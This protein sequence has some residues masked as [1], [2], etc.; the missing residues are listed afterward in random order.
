MSWSGVKE[1]GNTQ[2]K[3]KYHW[4][5]MALTRLLVL[6]WDTQRQN[7]PGEGRRSIHGAIRYLVSIF[8]YERAEQLCWHRAQLA[9]SSNCTGGR[10]Y[11]A[12]EEKQDPIWDD[13]SRYDEHAGEAEQIYIY[14]SLSLSLLVVRGEHHRHEDERYWI[15]S[16]E[17]CELTGGRL[18]FS[19]SKDHWIR[20]SRLRDVPGAWTEEQQEAAIATRYLA[21]GKRWSRWFP[22]SCGVCWLPPE[23]TYAETCP[24]ARWNSL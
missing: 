20:S 3:H 15:G 22:K 1:D 12:S 6:Y 14:L 24:A 7:F 11:Q 23:S 17:V 21:H 10:I 16:Q 18:V 19:T 13:C 8:M 4:I 5:A 2:F 9:P